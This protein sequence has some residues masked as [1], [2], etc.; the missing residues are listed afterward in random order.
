MKITVEEV[1]PARLDEYARIPS[2][3]EVLNVL[4]V[5]SPG[6]GEWGFHLE[7]EAVAQPYM[8]DYDASG[9]PDGVVHNWAKHFDVSNWRPWP[10]R[11]TGQGAKERR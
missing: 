11:A 1:G 2:A 5:E 3:F 10:A 9:D 7:E 8:K 4:R 6:P